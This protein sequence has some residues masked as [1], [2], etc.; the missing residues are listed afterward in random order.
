M[1]SVDCNSKTSMIMYGK[2]IL[3]YKLI[4]NYIYFNFDII[5]IKINKL[6]Y[7]KDL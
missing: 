6:F 2:M 7:M 3:Y 5:I 1:L 4:K